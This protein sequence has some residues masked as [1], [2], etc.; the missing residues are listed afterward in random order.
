MRSTRSAVPL[1]LAA[2]SRTVCK[3]SMPV[4]NICCISNDSFEASMSPACS[5]GAEG[6]PREISMI[7]SPS[8]PWVAMWTSESR[9][10]RSEYRRA[11]VSVT[12]TL[13]PGSGGST[14][15]VTRPICTP[16]RRTVAPSMSPPTSV[17]SAMRSYLRSK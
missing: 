1:R 15:P 6:E 3:V 13:P 8:R 5:G 4:L 16:A 9:R 2:S 14:T 11:T 17:N 7:L 10:I 12:R